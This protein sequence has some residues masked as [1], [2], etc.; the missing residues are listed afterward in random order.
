MF[1]TECTHCGERF[2]VP[3]SVV[4]EKTDCPACS[5]NFSQVP[6]QYEG[7]LGRISKAFRRWV[8]GLFAVLFTIGAFYEASQ[9][10]GDEARTIAWGVAFAMLL[11]CTVLIVFA[12]MA[13]DI[14]AIRR[15]LEDPRK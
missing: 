15:K 12:D 11:Q 8:I 14:S 6:Y 3:D 4:G 2:E 10:E 9:T 5:H 13:E 1:M 7:Q